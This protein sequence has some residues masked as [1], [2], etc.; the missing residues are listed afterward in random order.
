MKLRLNILIIALFVFFLGAGI[1]GT[2][3]VTI[4]KGGSGNDFVIGA[5]IGLLGTGLTALTSLGNNILEKDN[6]SG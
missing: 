5:L 6:T 2:L 3:L 1:L 4:M